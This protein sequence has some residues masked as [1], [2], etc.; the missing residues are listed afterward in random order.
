MQHT[1]LIDYCD[2]LAFIM[3]WRGY[4]PRRKQS[5]LAEKVGGNCSQ[6]IIN[7]LLNPDVGA[8][9]TKYNDRIAEVLQCNPEWLSTGKGAPA[10]DIT[11]PPISHQPQLHQYVKEPSPAYCVSTN[12]DQAALLEHHQERWPF[13]VSLERINRLPPSLI[14]R[15]DGYIESR[16]EEYE[17]N[18]IIKKSQNTPK[19][20]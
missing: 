7:R 3:Q 5:K 8:K 10:P 9:R 18:E 13:S 16:V 15:I 6:Q 4:D 17:R 11:W 19:N 20:T 1:Q 2:R 14:G 12:P